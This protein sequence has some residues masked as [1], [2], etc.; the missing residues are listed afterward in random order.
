MNIVLLV[1][2]YLPSTK[3][4]PL[5][6]QQLGLAFLRQGHSVTILAPSGDFMSGTRETNEDGL[7]VIRFRSGRLKNVRKLRRTIN[8]IML[9]A[10]VLRYWLFYPRIRKADLI[11]SYSPTIFWGAAIRIIKAFHG[12]KNY[13]IL[14]DIFPQ[15]AVDSGLLKE[16]SPITVF[17]RFFESINYAAADII[18]VQSPGCCEYFRNTRFS[19]KITVLYNWVELSSPETQYYGLRQKYQWED[20]TIFFYGGN[21]GL[22][23]DIDNLM[24][25][26]RAMKQYPQARFLFV[27]KGDAFSLV[28]RRI[29]EWHLSNTLLHPSV[30]QEDYMKI[31]EECDV[32]MITL[33]PNHKTQNIPG[34]LL[35]YLTHFKPVLASVNSNNDLLEL[36]PKHNSGFVSVNPDDK[37]LFHHAVLLLDTKIRKQMG[38]GAFSFA[39]RVFDVNATTQII[40][41]A[42]I[43]Q[44][45]EN[46]LNK[47]MI[48]NL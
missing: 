36:I 48:H 17:F 30:P 43:P 9:P 1:D 33:H 12:P 26:A 40:L 41:S 21:I 44:K 32:G 10:H 35:G 4:A 20:K 37:S 24:R 31:L 22:A 42:I 11:V 7:R 38:D 14:R 39:K 3:S 19:N 45:N 47:D 27:G 5:M 2:D 25:L 8:E 18:G 15:W 6:I 23:Q 16:H 34:K 13:L 28:E 46:V 29:E